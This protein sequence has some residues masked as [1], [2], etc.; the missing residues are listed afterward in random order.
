[1]RYAHWQCL[2]SCGAAASQYSEY[3]D[4]TEAG[5]D[6]KSSTKQQQF[7]FRRSRRSAAGRAHGA[8]ALPLRCPLAAAQR[9]RNAACGEQWTFGSIIGVLFS[10]K[11]GKEIN[12][13]PSRIIW[14]DD[15]TDPNKVCSVLVRTSERKYQALIQLDRLA[16]TE[17]R[18]RLA[19]T[20]RAESTD[21]EDA[22]NVSKDVAH[23][24][25]IPG[26]Q[27]ARATAGTR[28]PMLRP[29]SGPTVRIGCS[30]VVERHT[31]LVPQVVS[32]KTGRPSTR[33][34]PGPSSPMAARSS[35]ASAGRLS[36]R[37]GR[38]CASC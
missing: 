20:W 19:A 30:L 7:V 4:G 3:R 28:S 8:R 38:S 35:A 33:L 12:A 17:E 23:H 10:T 2:T 6:D 1:L 32:Q 15:A 9:A 27:T 29:A 36:R 14:Q 21:S 13:L 16:S 5:T 26:G 24:V 34:T 22:Q 18:K 37:A 31:S 25:R 11:S